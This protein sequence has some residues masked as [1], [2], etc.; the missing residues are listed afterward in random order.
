MT[1]NVNHPAHYR[2]YSVEVIEIVRKM[3]FDQG[4]VIKYLLRAPFKGRYHEDLKKAAWYLDDMI[5][6]NVRFKLGRGA[7][8]RLLKITKD[9]KELGV[10][11]PRCRDVMCV[12]GDIACG[13]ICGAARELNE[14]NELIAKEWKKE[15][16]NG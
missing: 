14:L 10:E 15:N 8:G 1:D 9:L 5:Q 7:L 11:D 2:M 12:I 13:D 3:S 6:H 16:C 4:N